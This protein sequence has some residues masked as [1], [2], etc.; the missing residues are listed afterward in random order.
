MNDISHQQNNKETGDREFFSKIFRRRQGL[1]PNPAKTAPVRAP[2]SGVR[3]FSFP[4]LTREQIDFLNGPEWSEPTLSPP[5][6]WSQSHRVVEDGQTVVREGWLDVTTGRIVSSEEVSEAEKKGALEEK[7]YV[8]R[9]SAW[10]SFLNV[11]MKMKRVDEKS[12]ERGISLVETVRSIA[13]GS[14]SSLKWFWRQEKH[15]SDGVVLSEQERERLF[16]DWSSDVSGSLS[17]KGASI[18]PGKPVL[19]IKSVPAGYMPCEQSVFLRR[20]VSARTGRMTGIMPFSN[21]VSCVANKGYVFWRLDGVWSDEP[22]GWLDAML[23]LT[24]QGEVAEDWIRARS[25]GFGSREFIPGSLLVPAGVM[26]ERFGV[27]GQRINYCDP[28]VFPEMESVD[29]YRSFDFPDVCQEDMEKADLLMN[30]GEYRASLLNQN[31]FDVSDRIFKWIDWMTDNARVV[32][33]GNNGS[34]N[35]VR[36]WSPQDLLNDF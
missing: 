12:A 4:S 19:A 32:V 16:G 34:E 8:D 11:S 22:P 30:E 1:S 29:S 20:V 5:M 27:N 13:S 18:V 3:L 15:L 9:V 26:A 21:G 25:W 7:S 10:L 35:V 28:D 2:S 17:S 33:V 31:L 6:V 36:K 14:V 23:F 24:S